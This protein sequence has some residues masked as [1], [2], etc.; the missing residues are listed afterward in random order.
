MV[1]LVFKAVLP[2]LPRKQKKNLVASSRK[3]LGKKAQNYS[4]AWQCT[5]ERKGIVS[6]MR[7]LREGQDINY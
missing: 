3:I 4:K 7:L 1:G 2:R 6:C 5:A